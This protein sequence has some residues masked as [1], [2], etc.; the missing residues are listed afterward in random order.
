MLHIH[1]KARTTPA[2]R[3]EIARSEE[4]TCV[5]ATH[6][7]ISMET[8]R[9]GGSLPQ[10]CAADRAPGWG[11]GLFGDRRRKR[12][13][14]CLAPR[15]SQLAA[16]RRRGSR[17]SVPSRRP[18]RHHG[19]AGGGGLDAYPVPLSGIRSC[20][21]PRELHAL[22]TEPRRMSASRIYL[23]VPFLAVAALTACER[24]PGEHF[25]TTDGTEI[26]AT[27]GTVV[28]DTTPYRP[29]AP[30]LPL[31]EGEPGEDR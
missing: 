17:C 25:E 14:S 24:A 4:P 8:V 20:I 28:N 9:M 27:G 3:A 6:Y 29:G 31:G 16:D 5:L 21:A 7:G 22:T 19:A 18:R 23:I 15:E 12:G 26:E 10:C 2:V 13:D 1:P 11:S 30:T